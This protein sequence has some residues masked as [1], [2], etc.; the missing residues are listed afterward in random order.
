MQKNESERM[1]SVSKV[2]RGLA[3]HGIE[4]RADIRATIVAMP[5]GG[6][7]PEQRDAVE[8]FNTP[9]N[10]DLNAL[11]EALGLE[12]DNRRDEALKIVERVEKFEKNKK[13][14]NAYDEEPAPPAGEVQ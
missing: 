13:N 9:G 5:R 1:V 7:T 4:N 8:T 2:E 14:Q 6:I 3:F 10:G 12:G 11:C